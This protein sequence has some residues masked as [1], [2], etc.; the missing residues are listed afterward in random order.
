MGTNQWLLPDILSQWERISERDHQLIVDALDA[1]QG[2]V[3]LTL[4]CIHTHLW[5]QS[6]VAAIIR[7]GEKG[8]LP[9]EIRKV[10]WDNATKFEKEFQSWWYS[11]YFTFMTPATIRLRLLS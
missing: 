1:A 5:M 7:K 9:T 11:V 6:M 10:I 8:T 4:S 2:N 3:F